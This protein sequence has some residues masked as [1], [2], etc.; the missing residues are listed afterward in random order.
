MV[1]PSTA[2]T[3]NHGRCNIIKQDAIIIYACVDNNLANAN[4]QSFIVPPRQAGV[5]FT[6]PALSQ[7]AELQSWGFCHVS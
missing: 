7:I 2:C 6:T 1:G 3:A 4:A 5:E